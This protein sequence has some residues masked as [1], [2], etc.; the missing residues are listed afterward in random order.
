MNSTTDHFD[1]DWEKYQFT[2]SVRFQVAWNMNKVIEFNWTGRAQ[3]SVW[4]IMA[5]TEDQKLIDG[6]HRGR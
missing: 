5:D 3:A 4:G 1:L 6:S 2:R